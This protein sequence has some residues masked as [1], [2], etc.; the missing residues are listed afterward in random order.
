MMNQDKLKQMYAEGGLL[1]ALLKDPAQREM[2]RKML[3]M[4]EGGMMKKYRMGGSMEYA[5]GGEME[6]PKGT[7]SA[8]EFVRIQEPDLREAYSSFAYDNEMGPLENGF[9]KLSESQRESLL[10]RAA[11]LAE[12]RFEQDKAGAKGQMEFESEAYESGRFEP[13]RSFRPREAGPM[14]A[15]AQREMD[16]EEMRAFNMMERLSPELRRRFGM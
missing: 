15:A 12:K 11:M 9:S 16:L 8:G 13:G 5:D 2:A 4:E 10:S 3:T 1:K 14:G 6:P 7:R